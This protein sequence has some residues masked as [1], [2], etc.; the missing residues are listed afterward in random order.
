MS[1]WLFIQVDFYIT[2]AKSNPKEED[3]GSTNK[4]L[5]KKKEH[6]QVWW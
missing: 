3:G 2:R 1:M 6:R 5:F 4:Y